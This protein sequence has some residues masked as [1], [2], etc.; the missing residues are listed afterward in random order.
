MCASAPDKV[1]TRKIMMRLATDGTSVSAANWS[2]P[3]V[4]TK[5]GRRQR[6]FLD[7]TTCDRAKTP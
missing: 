1:R 3:R 5:Q 4:T 6:F 7:L 2:P